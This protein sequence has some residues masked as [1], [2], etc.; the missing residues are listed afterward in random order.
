M[1]TLATFGDLVDERGLQTGKRLLA[2]PHAEQRQPEMGLGGQMIGL[3][4]ERLTIRLGSRL[5]MARVAQRIANCS[6][7]CNCTSFAHT[8]Q[9]KFCVHSG[10]YH[11]TNF[12]L[13]YFS[14][15]GE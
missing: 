6:G 2:T 14:C 3:K 9:P 1:E 7:R 13:G 5:Q 15:A 11:M 8:F 10:S 12:D 4:G